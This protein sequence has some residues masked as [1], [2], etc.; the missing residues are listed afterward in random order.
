M[1]SVIKMLDVKKIFELMQY[2][3]IKNIRTLS[4]KA[5]IPYTTLSYMFSGHDMHVST[6]IE[7]SK[8]FNV[9]MDYLINKSYGIVSYTDKE[10]IYVP[11]SSIIEATVKV[12]M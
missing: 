4:L 11:T 5:K 3:D 8:F 10:Q 12:M 6:L 7:L 2:K 1:N 9:P